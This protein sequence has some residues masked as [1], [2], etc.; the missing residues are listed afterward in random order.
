MNTDIVNILRELSR[1]TTGYRSSAYHRAAANIAKLSW[2]IRD[3]QTKYKT[4]KIPGVGDGVREKIDE[5]LTTGSIADLE[6]LK[7][8]TKSIEELESIIGVG[9]VTA[10]EWYRAGIY[11]IKQLREAVGI[12]KVTLTRLQ[13]IGLLYYDDLIQ[14]I[15]RNEVTEIGEIVMALVRQKWPQ[16]TAEIVGSYRRGAPDSG[17]VDMI[18]GLRVFDPSFTEYIREHLSHIATISIGDSRLSFLFKL[19]NNPVRQI[20]ILHVPDAEYPASLLYF[21]GSWEFNERMR[22]YAKTKGFRLNQRGIFRIL[23]R[24]V[25]DSNP[26]PVT[27]ERDIFNVIGWPYVEPSRRIN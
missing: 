15:P 24:G 10:M 27:S 2:S 20:D 5:Y 7:K 19:R 14:R 4:I 13:S 16:V 1:N 6:Q 23:S 25:I 17:D 22:S 3:D 12:G 26:I 21:T 8:I 9:E 11:T 18:C